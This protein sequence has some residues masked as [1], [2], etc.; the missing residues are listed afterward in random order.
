M[1]EIYLQGTDVYD[2]VL[3]LR[4]DPR[5]P[6]WIHK[7]TVKYNIIP[8]EVRS[9]GFF[10]RTL[11]LVSDSA[12]VSAYLHRKNTLHR[13]YQA[14]YEFCERLLLHLAKTRPETLPLGDLEKL[15][16]EYPSGRVDVQESQDIERET[17]Q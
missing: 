17:L 4:C 13:Q 6:H 12:G 8:S 2:L 11:L 5:M 1:T 9:P 14:D 3:K 7:P 15:T 16:G 10:S